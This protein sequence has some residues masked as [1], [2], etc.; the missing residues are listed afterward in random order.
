MDFGLLMPDG[1]RT[2][3][4]NGP[5]DAAGNWTGKAKLGGKDYTVQARTVAGQ[6]VVT[7][8]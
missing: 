1:K 7:F 3:V 6:V 4:A 5:L 2:S 8:Q